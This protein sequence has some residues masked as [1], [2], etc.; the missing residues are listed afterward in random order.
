M[1]IWLLWACITWSI[2]IRHWFY[3]TV[4][5]WTILELGIYNCLIVCTL[6][7][8]SE[9]PEILNSRLRLM[10]PH[11]TLFFVYNLQEYQIIKK[12]ARSLSTVQVE[13]PWRLAQ[14]SI[15]SNIVLMKGQGKVS[16]PHNQRLLLFLLLFLSIYFVW[17]L[18][19]LNFYL[20]TVFCTSRNER[21]SLM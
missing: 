9:F 15:I 8:L 5:L 10:L 11:A 18:F 21:L 13:S 1:L 4:L 17:S 14:P 19:C 2:V 16:I 3:K 6:L 7:W 12:S 20:F